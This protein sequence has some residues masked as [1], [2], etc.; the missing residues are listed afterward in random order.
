MRAAVMRVDVELT[1]SNQ[2]QFLRAD[3]V[4]CA[5]KVEVGPW[6]LVEPEDFA[7][8]SLTALKLSDVQGHVIDA[9][10]FHQPVFAEMAPTVKCAS[11]V[12]CDPDQSLDRNLALP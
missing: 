4:P 7:V 10:D 8:E 6:E 1:V 2:V 5:G 11:C 12:L 9:E 3:R